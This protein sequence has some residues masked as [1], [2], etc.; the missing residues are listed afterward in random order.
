MKLG[1]IMIFVSDLLKAKHFY[2]EVLDFPLKS[3]AE[4]RL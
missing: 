1:K 2:C 3:E 4:N